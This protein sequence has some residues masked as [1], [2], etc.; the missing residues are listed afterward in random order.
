[1]HPAIYPATISV[2]RFSTTP[3]MD[4]DI[5]LYLSL[6]ANS[7]TISETFRP[8]LSHLLLD[9]RTLIAGFSVSLS[10]PCFQRT[11][12][13]TSVIGMMFYSGK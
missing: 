13:Y 5:L 3:F 8:M 1:M 12:L 9:W 11:F 10:I 2:G 4:G 6:S 7:S